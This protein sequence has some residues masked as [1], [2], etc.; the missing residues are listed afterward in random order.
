MAIIVGLVVT[1]Q[2]FYLFILENL[3]QFGALKAIGVTNGTM[4]LMVLFQ[5]LLVWF[6]GVGFGTALSSTFFNISPFVIQLRHFIRF[7]E[8]AV[9]VAV[10]MLLVIGL[11]SSA[12]LIRVIR[13][14][15]GEVFR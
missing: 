12:G 11:A 6:V 8:S 13:L 10:F 4:L 15:P 14:Q 7:W 3:R 9:G 2:T 1:G 5:S